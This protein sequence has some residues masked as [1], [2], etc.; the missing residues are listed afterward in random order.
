VFVH[1]I[2][3]GV[4]MGVASLRAEVDGDGA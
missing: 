1:V 2:A 3:G 4:L